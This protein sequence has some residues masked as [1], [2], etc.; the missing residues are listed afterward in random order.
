MK[1][2]K[3]FTLVELLVVIAIIALLVSIL[4]P[5]LSSAR[6]HARGLMCISHVRILAQANAMYADE[7][8]DKIVPLGW[9]LNRQ[10][11]SL[12]GLDDLEI[13]KCMNPFDQAIPTMWDGWIAAPLPADYICPDSA[14]AR[15]GAAN[16]SALAGTYGYNVGANGGPHPFG[17]DT[18]L[19]DNF[20]LSNISLTS[21]KIMFVESSDNCVNSDWGP[22]TRTPSGID[23]YN[24]LTYGDVGGSEADLL[25]GIVAYRHNDM[26]S[27]VYFDGHAESKGMGELWALD[28]T[29]SSDN[30]AMRVMWALH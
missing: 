9:I 19:T 17:W 5:A 22:Y 20:K 14:V 18:W 21:E 29:G 10:F 25:W 15:Q 8:N 3:A 4:M 6:R 2:K 28:V 30:A 26:S 7:N 24:W 11:L 12:M 23:P 13:E 16:V 1:K 27:V